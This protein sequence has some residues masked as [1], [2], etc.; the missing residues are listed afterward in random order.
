MQEDTY[1]KFE[2]NHTIAAAFDVA[3][4]YLTESASLDIYSLLHLPQSG[5]AQP[6]SMY[7]KV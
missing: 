7:D 3:L 4:I 2:S 6:C 1:Q 5:P